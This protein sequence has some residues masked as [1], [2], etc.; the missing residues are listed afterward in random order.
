MKK[1]M[2]I[3]VCFIVIASIATAAVL[4]VMSQFSVTNGSTGT[5]VQ[6]TNAPI[7]ATAV[8][9]MGFSAPQTA[10]A[11]DV[12]VSYGLSDNGAQAVKVS[13]G[14]IVNLALG[15]GRA[16]FVL[17][18]IWMDVATGNDGLTVIYDQVK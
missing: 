17:S 3:A 8:T 15:E 2:S 11:G 4:S 13:S 18:N 16:F 7:V 1:V 12:Y 10:N 5:P 9:L 6:I 14:S